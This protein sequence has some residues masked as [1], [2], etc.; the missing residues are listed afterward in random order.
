MQSIYGKNIIDSLPNNL[1]IP[2]S[3]KSA[4]HLLFSSAI[5]EDLSTVPILNQA[6]SV[7]SMQLLTT[8]WCRDL[9]SRLNR[10]EHEW[11]DAPLE[12]SFACLNK[13]K[14]FSVRSNGGGVG[15]P[16]PRGDDLHQSSHNLILLSLSKW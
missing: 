2:S 5:F 3:K 1:S 6:V 11:C 7:D 10:D 15:V 9:P 16:N 13:F 14:V 8:M 4:N 12:A